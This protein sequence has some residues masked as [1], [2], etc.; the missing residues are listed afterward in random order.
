MHG[1]WLYLKENVKCGKHTDVLCSSEKCSNKHSFTPLNK[2]LV[3]D[4]QLV[5]P[6]RELIY[7]KNYS[8]TRLY[9]LEIGDPSRKIVEIIFQKASLDHSKS[10][11]RI[12]SIL[13]VKNST[14]TLDSFEKY[15]DKV[16]MIADHRCTKNP[17]NIV[18]GNEQLRFYG[19][20][21]SCRRERS[22][23]VSELCKNPNCRVCR[24]L[25]SNF[26]ID[27]TTN[28][29]IHLSSSSDEFREKVM[30][31]TERAVIV[32]RIIAGNESI[33]ND[34]ESTVCNSTGNEKGYNRSG[35]AIVWN[36]SAVLPCFVIVFT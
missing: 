14:Q 13:K 11:T 20:T 24:I 26:H 10:T 30:K 33:S 36:P 21:M 6:I 7:R 1:M 34:D 35:N 12:K 15:R 28:N 5:H 3:P 19:T 4:S 22:K 31:N 23:R 2:N 18:D 16:K 9:E 25:Q 32:C 29:G 27:Y 17:R 8:Q